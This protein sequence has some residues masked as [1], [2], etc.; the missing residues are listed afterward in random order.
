MTQPDLLAWGNARAAARGWRA[1]QPSKRVRLRALF[2]ENR[3]LTQ[4]E[5]I[6]VLG[7]RFGATL[8]DIHHGKD[9]EGQ[10]HYVREENEADDSFVRY[11]PTQNAAECSGCRDAH[12]KEDLR[13]E[14]ERLRAENAQL[15]AHV[16]TLLAEAAQ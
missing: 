2:A 4:A 15:R 9:G 5:L 6:A 7:H 8:W 10:A 12:R 16:A 3:W 1:K 14:N 13:A 11:R